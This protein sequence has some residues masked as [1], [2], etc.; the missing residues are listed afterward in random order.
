[1]SIIDDIK[2]KAEIV[3]IVSPYVT[4]QQTGKNLK[5]LCPFHSEKT[6]SFFISPER[7]TWRCFGACSDGGDI[8]S[9]M[10]KIENKE[11][12]ETIQ[13][14]ANTLGIDNQLNIQKDISKN[15]ELFEIN[16]RTIRRWNSLYNNN[17][18][19]LE[20]RSRPN[21]SYKLLN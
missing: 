15:S 2:T 21:I 10:M 16:E 13:S 8:I 12:A 7:Q 18:N 14:L 17:N 6:P 20:R 4:L 1:M 19:N 5:G 9:F 3:Q 11:F